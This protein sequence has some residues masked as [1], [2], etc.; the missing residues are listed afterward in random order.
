VCRTRAGFTLIE[1]LVVM[2]IIGILMALLIP[3]VNATRESARATQSRNN[4]RQ[5]A[6][7]MHN[8]NSARTHYPP[9]YYSYEFNA[10]DPTNDDLQRWDSYKNL[11]G[12]SVH[13]LL[14]PYLEQKII[15]GDIDYSVPYNF[16]ASEAAGNPSGG[17][18]P[19]FNLADGT[20]AR[21]GTIRVP[22]YL[23][24]AEPRDEVRENLHHPI[25]Y[26][27][28]LGTWF[29]WDPLTGK[30]GNGAAYPNSQLKDGA[31]GDGLSTT[32]AFAEVKAW[33]PYFRDSF[34]TAVDCGAPSATQPELATPPATPTDLGTIMGT[35]NEYKATAHTE[36]FN[37]HA[38]H[39]GFTTVFRPNQRVLNGNSGSPVTVNAT[40]TGNLDVD[41]TNKQ[42][43][44]NH[45][46]STPE[47]SPTYAAI[48]ARSYFQGG[49]NV[50]MMD[51]SVRNIGDNINLG[52]WRALSTRN[53]GERLPNSVGQ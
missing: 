41:W 51:G 26:V 2:L 4:L 42:E 14:L 47:Y 12:W 38:H 36:W 53:G 9:S 43:G 39:A 11:E 50:A 1:L 46:S 24:P 20:S 33:N 35:P 28:N 16:Y 52:V 7:A 13:T 32:L 5:I 48:T 21:L 18:P 34:R 19:L 10:N 29:V 3:A 44:K 15:A 22:A 6:L 30:G 27:M 49:V 17:A 31:F 25:N 45:F 8:F 23:S 40:G 37:G